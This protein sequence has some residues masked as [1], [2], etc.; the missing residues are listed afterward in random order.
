MNELTSKPARHFLETYVANDHAKIA[1][2]TKYRVHY[3]SDLDAFS[4]SFPKDGKAGTDR[5]LFKRN[6]SGGEYRMYGIMN[7]HNY[8]KAAS[9]LKQFKD[10]CIHRV[11]GI[12]QKKNQ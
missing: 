6:P 8:D 3:I 12:Y 4:I 7:D 11:N 9:N 10:N 5:V 1:S 2:E